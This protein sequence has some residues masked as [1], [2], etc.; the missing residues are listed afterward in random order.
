MRAKGD[1]TGLTPRESLLVE[2][3]RSLL[4]NRSLSD[5]LYER[6]M[7]E[8][9]RQQLLETITLTGHYSLIGLVIN[10]FDVGLTDNTPTF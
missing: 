1:L 7:A 3:V 10:G 5:E 8:L 9:G 2:T 6:G 4:R